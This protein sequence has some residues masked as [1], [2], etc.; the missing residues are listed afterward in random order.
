MPSFEEIPN[1]R[2]EAEKFFDEDQQDRERHL[3]K[4]DPTLFAEREKARYQKAQEMFARYKQNPQTLSVDDIYHLAFLFQHGQTPEDY[5]KAHELAIEAEKQGREEAKWLTA[6]T[7]DRYLLSLGKKQKW[8]TQFMHTAE[9]WRYATP[10][11][12]DTSSGITD[13]MRQSRNVPARDSQLRIISEIYHEPSKAVMKTDKTSETQRQWDKVRSE[14]EDTADALGYEV[15]DGI[16]EPVIALNAFSINTHQSCEGHTDHGMSAPWISIEAPNEPEERFIG[17]NDIFKKVAKK[18]NL[19]IE[20]V[21]GWRNE[22]AYQEAVLEF[23]ENGETKD[24][25]KWKIGSVKLLYIIN[26][27]LDDFYKTRQVPNNIKLQ[28]NIENF[29]DMAEGN[30]RI[31]NGGD[32]YRSIKDAKLSEEERLTL[33]KRLDEYRQEMQTFANFLKDKFFSDGENYIN[34]KRNNAQERIDR[35]E[36]EKI[37]KSFIQKTSEVNY[38]SPIQELLDNNPEL[39]KIYNERSVTNKLYIDESGRI[40]SDGQIYENNIKMRALVELA[41]AIRKSLP[42][43]QNGHIRLWRG[44]RPNEV[45]YNPSYTNSLEGIALPFLRGYNGVLS[46]VDV[47]H[48]EA[49]KYMSTGAVA[50]D[51]EFILPSD[52]V[53]NAKIVGFSMEEAYEIKKKA[54][55]LFENTQESGWTN[56]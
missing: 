39:A 16:K 50:K 45:G 28:V 9:G 5:S 14:I 47:S 56:I 43:I 33:G 46:Y 21:K 40:V 27:I 42:D 30:F 38:E 22:D 26:E 25:Q 12:E 55:P 17:Q 54:M 10:M 6:A 34:K 36:I 35:E 2:I 15:D 31:F 4:T 29:E 3:D 20:D 48:E 13:D 52:V 11:E 18:Y 24:F 8:G 23:S 19:P 53:K 51:S 49:K 41:N 1:N 37:R 44:N 32:D 7:E